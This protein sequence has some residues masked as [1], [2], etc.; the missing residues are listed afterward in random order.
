MQKITALIRYFSMQCRKSYFNCFG[1]MLRIFRLNFFKF[2]LRFSKVTWIFNFTSIG[3]NSKTFQ[4]QVN[5]NSQ[6]NYFFFNGCILNFNRQSTI[7]L[8]AGFFNGAGFYFCTFGNIP[9]YTKFYLAY[10]GKIYPT[11][12]HCKTGLRVADRMKK[13]L[14][15]ESWKARF[16]IPFHPTE[17]ILK[18]GIQ[19]FQNVL[20]DLRVYFLEFR[21]SFFNFWQLVSL[22][23]IG[24]RFSSFERS[25]TMF[26]CNVMKQ[27]TKTKLLF[28]NNNLLS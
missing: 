14:S 23:F 24:N 21:K 7:P 19:A 9:M 6:G 13:I 3:K 15:F 10:C 5:A 12:C 1:F 4:A 25:D 20:Q 2:F 16:F 11:P 28:N 17:K 27:A 18:G 8:I 26:E 22:L